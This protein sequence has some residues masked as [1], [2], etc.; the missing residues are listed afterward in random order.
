MQKIKNL[1]RYMGS[2]IITICIL[3]INIGVYYNFYTSTYDNLNQQTQIYLND[4]IEEASECVNIK[5][6][7][8][9]NTLEALSLFIGSYKS[10]TDSNVIQ[11]MDA[12][13]SIDGFSDYDIVGLDGKGLE[14]KG[15]IN[16]VGEKFFDKTL[17]GKNSIVAVDDEYGNLNSIVFAVPIYQ[18]E[19]I[20]GMLAVHC[21]PE[22][23][24]NFVDVITFGNNGNVF[25]V[26]QNGELLS[27]GNGLDEV[28]SISQILSDHGKAASKLISSMKQ[29][30]VGNVVYGEGTS[31]KYLCFSRISY[32][33]WYI[34]SIVS[35]EN[36]EEQTT[37][38][39]SD[40]QVFIIEMGAMFLLLIIY[41][42]YLVA[43]HIKN[44]QINKQR[45]FI[46]TDNSDTVIID[47]SVKKDTMYCNDKWKAI[48]G[49]ELPKAD[50][51]ETINKYVYEEDVDK[52]NRK[53]GRL[54]K[55]ND[56]V[57]FSIRLIDENDNPI[58]CLVKL[59]AIKGFRGKITKILGIIETMAREEESKKED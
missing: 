12:Q 22:E 13:T 47:Y 33:K 3:L 52:F 4:Q 44:G 58:T 55:T 14:E 32:N 21:T 16:Y 23:F 6:E 25:I 38:I 26:K 37:L 9:L 49:Y 27:R 51:K 2:I 11:V 7:E 20:K 45:Y 46:A 5:I 17:E 8:R 31:K 50:V 34:V 56:F 35:A 59:Y 28:E 29:K 41:F 30:S 18:D 42:I 1:K 53:I 48:F 19:D 24:T 15:S 43:S 57:K 54:N 39:Q 40:G 36:V 10:V